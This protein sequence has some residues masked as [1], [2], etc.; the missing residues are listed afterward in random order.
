MK[1]TLLASMGFEDHD[2]KTPLHD[3][4]VLWCIEHQAEILKECGR[5]NVPVESVMIE[6]PIGGNRIVGY[7]DILIC[8]KHGY[9]VP[10]VSIEVKTKIPSLGELVRQLR[11][12]FA[13]RHDVIQAVV[14]PDDRFAAVLR[15]QGFAFIRYPGPTRISGDLF[16]SA[17]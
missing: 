5:E 14:C 2:L 4:I 6:A 15:S 11:T 16:G 8:L 13:H 3:E 12:L 7:S 17:E 10:V 9:G 1:N